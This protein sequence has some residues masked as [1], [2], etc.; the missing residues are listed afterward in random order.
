VTVQLRRSIL[1]VLALTYKSAPADKVA[2]ALDLN[3]ADDI[4][5]IKCSCVESV[6]TDAV[7]FAATRENTKRERVYQ[8]GLGF[9]DISEMMSKIVTAE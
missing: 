8:E 6:T 5:T 7:V 2:T 9:G 1:E 4:R 3:S